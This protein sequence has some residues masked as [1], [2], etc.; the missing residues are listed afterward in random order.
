MLGQVSV[1]IVWVEESSKEVRMLLRNIRSAF[2]VF[3]ILWLLGFSTPLS[4]QTKIGGNIH[5]G[6]I[7]HHLRMCSDFW[8]SDM[9]APDLEISTATGPTAAIPPGQH[10]DVAVVVRNN[11]TSCIADSGWSVSLETDTLELGTY[12]SDTGLGSLRSRSITVDGMVPPSLSSSLS[13]LQVVARVA[14]NNFPDYVSENDESEPFDISILWQPKLVPTEVNQSWNGIHDDLYV[15]LQ[16]QGS[17]QSCGDTYDEIVLEKLVDGVYYEWSPEITI[18][19][20]FPVNRRMDLYFYTDVA[21]PKCFCDDDE[22][23][24]SVVQYR[25]NIGTECI[26]SG[27]T[28]SANPPYYYHH[29]PVRVPRQYLNDAI[30]CQNYCD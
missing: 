14:A 1:F 6:P 20:D 19:P 22:Y 17:S 11:S 30:W 27:L 13:T 28:E 18:I 24:V 23:F 15:T 26:D 4:A 3:T 21:N 10:F 16:N 5:P 2:F 29:Y 12:Y 9:T 25:A 8:K 7:V